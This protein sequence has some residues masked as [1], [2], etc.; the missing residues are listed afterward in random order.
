V[1]F[2]GPRGQSAADHAIDEAIAGAI[3]RKEERRWT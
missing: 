1:S 2:N 3:A